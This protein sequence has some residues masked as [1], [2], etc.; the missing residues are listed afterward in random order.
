LAAAET[1]VRAAIVD[2]AAMELPK[3]TF[4]GD[5]LMGSTGGGPGRHGVYALSSNGSGFVGIE[6]PT[7]GD[8]R[9]LVRA[10]AQ[11]AGPDLARMGLLLDKKQVRAWDVKGQEVSGEYLY[12][13]HLNSGHY[14]V[15]VAFLNDYYQPSDPDP[16]NRDRNLF[17]EE[18]RLVGPLNTAPPPAPESHRRIF[19]V[20]QQPGH[21]NE[22]ARLILERFATRAFRRPVTGGELDRLTA[23]CE[24]AWHAG[25]SFE[26]GVSVALQAVLVSP[27]FLFR[28]E[29]QPEPDNPGMKAQID[30]FALASR[31]SYFLWSTMPDEELFALASKGRLRKNLEAQVRRMLAD[32]KALA[33]VE[34]FGGQW[35]QT[36]NLELAAP[37]KKTYPA[38]DDELRSAMR[39][40]TEMF[41]ASIL[42]GDR[43]VFDLINGE[44]TFVN[45]QLARLYGLPGVQGAE[46]R[47]VSLKGTG[48]AGVL[49]Q[50]S[51]LT[52]TSNPTRTSPV[53]RGKWVLENLLAQ[54]PPP[55][56]A[57]VPPLNDSKEAATESSLRQR[58][59]VHRANPLCA[60]C[61]SQM[62]PIGFS[63]ENFDGIGAWREKDGPFAVDASG[64]LPSGESFDG[65]ME[66]EHLI[67]SARR[68]QFLKCLSEKM[69]TYALGRGLEPYDRCAVE[70][71]TQR[72]AR[73]GNRFSAL[74][75]GIVESVPFQMRRGES[76]H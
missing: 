37:D 36:R 60:S 12:E 30:E 59:E 1:I 16:K 51:V 68:E 21:T 31:L 64:K 20:A 27:H 15:E 48:R 41:L 13:T 62:D 5:M 54:A 63:L 69:L 3:R 28:G 71:I 72:V 61:H 33:L 70:K 53:K 75:L 55:P 43:S 8:Y 74:I 10:Y 24:S 67:S 52:V 47:R 50:G 26:G 40:E 14:R 29:L 32:P 7:N 45:E 2:P 39:Q 76:S 35:L 22:T 42:R 4:L 34:N 38:F 9:V 58:M 73:K 66:L 44:Y 57:N 56:P 18:V 6:I 65:A 19:F 49:T 46:F 23:L 25:G 11:Q 17:V